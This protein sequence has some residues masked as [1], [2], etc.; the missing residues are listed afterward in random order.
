MRCKVQK[1]LRGAGCEILAKAVPMVTNP[2]NI[3][4]GAAFTVLIP[5]Q[6]M[7]REEYEEY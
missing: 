7:P 2:A 6:E 1:P 4:G 3:G 5:E